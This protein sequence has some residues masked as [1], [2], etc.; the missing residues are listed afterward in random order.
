MILEIKKQKVIL[1]LLQLK[2]IYT[3]PEEG[4]IYRTRINQHC[5]RPVLLKGYKNKNG[6]LITTLRLDGKKF[7][8]LLHHIIYLSVNGKYSCDKHVDHLN[9]NKIDNRISNLQLL[10][11][12]E[13]AA[14]ASKDGLMNPLKGE[15]VHNSILTRKKVLEIR[16]LHDKGNI[17]YQDLAIKFKTTYHHIR[18]V[19]KRERWT[20]L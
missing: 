1:K 20:H 5:E 6:Y 15:N 11:P 12:K 3:K 14:K 13:N 18:R 2:Y 10:T 8:P 7:H 19:A 16:K 17:N 4:V 9:N